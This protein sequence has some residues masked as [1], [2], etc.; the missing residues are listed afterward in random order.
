MKSRGRPSV[1]SWLDLIAAIAMLTT[2][3]VL[4]HG[5]FTSGRDGGAGFAG[6]P[7]WNLGDKVEAVSDQASGSVQTV[8]L[9]VRSSCRYCTESMPLYRDI[10]RQRSQAQVILAGPEPT[11]VLA[12]YAALHDF[13]PD[14]VL[15]ISP[16][17]LP[18]AGTPTLLVLDTSSSVTARWEGVLSKREQGELLRQVQ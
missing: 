15:S 11:H 4:L 6:K 1:R 7:L 13:S 2:A 3:S 14:D 12:A 9:V 8:L 18:V 10:L 17:R 16:D 5:H